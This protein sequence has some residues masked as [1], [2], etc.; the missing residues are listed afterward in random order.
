VIRKRSNFVVTLVA[1]L[2]AVVFIVAWVGRVRD[3]RRALADADAAIAHGNVFDAIVAASA[4]AEAR[5]PGFCVSEEGFARLETI[6][7]EAET[8]A[9]DA[10]AFAA[11]RA[12]RAA[13]LA[14][15]IFS[16]HTARRTHADA[17]IARL[18]HRL[19]VAAVA[20]GHAPTEAASEERL[21]A[22]L[23]ESDVPAGTTYALIG[24]GGIAFLML[25]GVLFF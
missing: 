3:G 11:W 7:K 5:C 24:L 20:K 6:A 16:T 15:E 1:I 17:E 14:S 19:D 21:R 12:V 8:R 10:T 18:G 4:A 22:V 2:C 13:C 9:D 25:V 23:D